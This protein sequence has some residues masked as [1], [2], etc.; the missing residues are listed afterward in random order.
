MSTINPINNNTEKNS[1]ISYKT[2]EIET[3]MLDMNNKEIIKNMLE[4]DYEEKAFPSNLQYVDSF[5]DRKTGRSEVAN[6]LYKWQ[7]G[8]SILLKT[9]N[10]LI[11]K[12]CIIYLKRN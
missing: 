1:A 9:L 10:I 4:E 12:Y 8:L 6:L 5:V 7:W 3:A 11:D 2:Y